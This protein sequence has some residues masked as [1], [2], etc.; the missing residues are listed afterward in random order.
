MGVDGVLSGGFVY[1]EIMQEI[2]LQADFSVE[3]HLRSM[4]DADAG[5]ARN[6][7]RQRSDQ[8]YRHIDE[9]HADYR[10]PDRIQAGS[11]GTKG[12]APAPVPDHMAEHSPGAG[13][14]D[15]C[16]RCGEEHA[17]TAEGLILCPY[18]KAA[19]FDPT[20]GKV[21]GVSFLVPAD[22]A[23]P[24]KPAE[25]EPAYDRI[26]HSWPAKSKPL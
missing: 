12:P 6:A 2:T 20:T 15:R 26:D 25:D 3:L 1:V 23:R 10:L 7:H 9:V 21:T 14:T 4:V 11:A 18:V 16:P 19:T 24:S 5:D 8:A 13:V 17:M 22:Y